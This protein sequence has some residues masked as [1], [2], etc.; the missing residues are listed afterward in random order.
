M[1]ANLRY[2]L[3]KRSSAYL[4]CIFAYTILYPVN[5][6]LIDC[7]NRVGFKYA[8]TAS[9]RNNWYLE[10]ISN[11]FF[12]GLNSTHYVGL[13]V[14]ALLFFLLKTNAEAKKIYITFGIM[15]GI[16]FLVMFLLSF[17]VIH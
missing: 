5:N 10:C 2:L 11:R 9:E 4:V 13:L 8:E 15:Y 14:L 16:C 6:S 17:I 1:K 7:R 12:N 3:A